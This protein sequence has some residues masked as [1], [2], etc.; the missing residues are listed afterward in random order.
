MEKIH[1]FAKYKLIKENNIT[2]LKIV[3]ISDTSD[4]D[5]YTIVYVCD[6]EDLHKYYI[7]RIWSLKLDNF[8]CVD[9]IRKLDYKT[10]HTLNPDYAF[11]LMALLLYKINFEYKI[12]ICYD[13]VSTKSI[14]INSYNDDGLYEPYDESEI[15]YGLV[16]KKAYNNDETIIMAFGKDKEKLIKLKEIH[17]TDE[18]IVE[19]PTYS[20]TNIE[21]SSKIYFYGSLSTINI[22]LEGILITDKILT[23]NDRLS[24]NP[25]E[26][27]EYYDDGIINA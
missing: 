23:D 7:C 2:Y 24:C 17:N 9:Y 5:P 3:S 10:M 19:I 6:K 26:P 18:Y 21:T 13:K 25:V 11:I 22:C 12:H 1:V 27:Y 4:K 8:I 16:H 14:A 20:K 15:Y